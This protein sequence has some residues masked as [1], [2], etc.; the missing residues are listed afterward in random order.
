M[1]TVSAD[2]T[3]RGESNQ[4]LKFNM[5]HQVVVGLV[6]GKCNLDDTDRSE[7]LLLLEESITIQY[8]GAEVLTASIN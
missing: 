6:G 7:D 8:E 5:A 1:V 2:I 3:F 4:D